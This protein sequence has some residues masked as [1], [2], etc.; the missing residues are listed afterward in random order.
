MSENI[1]LAAVMIPTG[2]APAQTLRPQ[3]QN[4]LQTSFSTQN[5]TYNSESADPSV[6]QELPVRGKNKAFGRLL[7]EKL[8]NT[9]GT[10]AESAGADQKNQ[11]NS[12]KMNQETPLTLAGLLIA[13]G[14][15]MAGETTQTTPD[16]QSP[17]TDTI[18]LSGTEVQ[19]SV[20]GSS[21]AEGVT[22]AAPITAETQEV[23]TDNQ[24]VQAKQ[25][26]FADVLKDR[27]AATDS[28]VNTPEQTASDEI[29]PQKN[30]PQTARSPVSANAQ[31]EQAAQAGASA[32]K[33]AA[34]A[35]PQG[36]AL[37]DKQPNGN[38]P[39]LPQKAVEITADTPAAQRSPVMA[40]QPKPAADSTQTDQ[41]APEANAARKSAFLPDTLQQDTEQPPAMK[42]DTEAAVS[43]V[44][45]TAAQ[46]KVSVLNVAE[47]AQAS[48]V[49]T[50]PA[51]KLRA[52]NAVTASRPIEQI[53]QKLAAEPAV[54]A[55]Q[56]IRLTLTPAE[57]GT[58]RI[59]F[60]EQEGEVVGLLEVQKP[61]TRKELEESLPQLMTAMQTQGVQVR[62]IE[63]VQWN[64]P[65]QGTRDS[66]SEDFN[67]SAE[68]EF[69]QQRSGTSQ[70]GSSNN[71]QFASS[72]GFS[73]T[74]AGAAALDTPD[75]QQWFSDKGL[76]LYI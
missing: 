56:Q 12:A 68:R 30:W 32:D 71:R 7:N 11:K 41:A 31:Q 17:Q 34:D 47:K 74:I 43:E 54:R 48:A 50:L 44:S 35:R 9:Q 59:T 10:P 28:D 76:N 16:S 18:S 3:S 13:A 26:A 1:Q 45:V 70:E 75:A 61:Q 33:L 46:H 52:A 15:E 14:T 5:K 39:P 66:L 8:E 55:D 63:V 67:P 22:A 29:S 19:V 73:S 53:A 25:T 23:A 20:V 37:A 69:L 51:D 6:S 65:Q 4:P 72:N 49:E 42:F 36:K 60:K 62:R 40:A 2:P 58:V 38:L 24:P 27:T 57:L 64:A 21:L